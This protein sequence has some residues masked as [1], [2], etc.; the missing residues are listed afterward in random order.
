MPGSEIDGLA[1]GVPARRGL[2]VG[3]IPARSGFAKLLSQRFGV[4][5]FCRRALKT[6]NFVPRRPTR[7]L[8]DPS[9]S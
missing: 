1:R 5:S 6:G 7:D 4:A 9:C 3:E 2:E 8:S